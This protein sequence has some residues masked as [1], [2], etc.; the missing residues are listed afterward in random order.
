MRREIGLWD[1][2]AQPLHLKDVCTVVWSF[3]ML[4]IVTGQIVTKDGS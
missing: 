4:L 1:I 3:L 2:T